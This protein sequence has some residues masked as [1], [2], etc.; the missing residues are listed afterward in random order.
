MTTKLERP[1]SVNHQHILAVINSLLERS[2]R[3]EPVRI[4]DLGCGDGKLLG[5]VVESLPTL[6]PA[7]RLEPF[8]LDVF[9]AGTQ[10]PGYFETTREYLRTQHPAVDWADRLVLISTQDEW[11]YQDESFDFVMSNQVLEHVFNHEA[12]FRQIRR[13][14][15]P[16]GVGV[17]LFP[18]RNVLWEGHASMPLVHRVRDVDARARLMLLFARMGFQA[19]YHREKQRRG[20]GSLE[21]FARVYARALE[22][23]TNY[24]TA[25]QLGFA[26]EQ[27]GLKVS[28]T[29]TK[30]YFY[31]KALSYLGR[32]PPLY[33]DL[34][35]L[36]S[37]GLSRAM[38]PSGRAAASE[39]TSIYR[40]FVL[41]AY[42]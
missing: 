34:G 14:L 27:A 2:P 40:T 17:N 11:P 39:H 16:G 12:V 9:D 36:E 37:V 18:L 33:R 31:A 28:F 25:A 8:G 13:C 23:D 3:T 30:D 35:S 29:Y 32:R 15:R 1:T 42:R 41:W 38:G 7:L 24:P 26:A 6:R 10:V 5:Y 20:W 21:E 22:T 4:L 19:H